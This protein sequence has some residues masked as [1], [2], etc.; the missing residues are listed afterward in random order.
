MN[1]TPGS[2]LSLSTTFALAAVVSISGL[3][4]CS[5]A[6]K[7]IPTP[8]DSDITLDGQVVGHGVTT[9][10][11]KDKK[12]HYQL[13]IV[14]P[15]GFFRKAT[16]VNFDS[17]DTLS[18]HAKKDHSYYETFEAN[19][20]V[21]KSI[22]LEVADRFTV[23][24]AWLKLVGCVSDAIP[25]FEILD[26]ESLYLKSAWKAA[27]RYGDAVRTR[28]RIIVSADN[29]DPNALTFRLTI[30]SERIDSHGNVIGDVNRTF[31]CFIDVV[32]ATRARLVR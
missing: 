29:P 13:C 18:L 6:I 22:I 30:E 32:E 5:H 31:K 4:G 14:P 15:P 10:I 11:L 20:I 26:R 28:S 24:E 8:S 21:N 9:V 16:L 1:R 19:D 27:G 12:I 23:D 2:V 3:L 25:D 17:P 7:V